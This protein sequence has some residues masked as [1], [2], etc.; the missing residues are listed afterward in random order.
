MTLLIKVLGHILVKLENIK[1]R[2]DQQK[3]RQLMGGGNRIIQY[4]FLI[5]GVQNIVADDNIN[6]G[7]NILVLI[8]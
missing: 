4:P 3:I 5:T 6:I 2:Y 7:I 8:P 1:K